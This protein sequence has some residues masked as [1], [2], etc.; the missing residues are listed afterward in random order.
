M[1]FDGRPSASAPEARMRTRLTAS[2]PKGARK[3][4]LPAGQCA[5]ATVGGDGAAAQAKQGRTA[6]GRTHWSTRER[7]HG[8]ARTARTCGGKRHGRA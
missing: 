1:D 6:C 4:T 5:L 3:R 7:K 2:A 8:L